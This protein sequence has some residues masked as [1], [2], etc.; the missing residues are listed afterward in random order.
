[1]PSGGGDAGVPS[2]GVAL[3]IRRWW[4]AAAAAARRPP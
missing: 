4:A 2:G 1:V 3:T